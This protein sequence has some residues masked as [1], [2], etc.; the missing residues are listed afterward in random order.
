MPGMH[1][2]CANCDQIVPLGCP[3]KAAMLDMVGFR[4]R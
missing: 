4:S 1:D 3:A 2:E